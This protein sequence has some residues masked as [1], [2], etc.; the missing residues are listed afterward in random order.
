VIIRHR[1]VVGEGE[2]RRL[3]GLEGGAGDVLFGDDPGG[4]GLFDNA[5]ERVVARPT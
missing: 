5:A 2:L 3:E 4:L 1:A